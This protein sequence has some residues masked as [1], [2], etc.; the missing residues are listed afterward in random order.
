MV[1]ISGDFRGVVSEGYEELD[2]FWG[3]VLGCG[4]LEGGIGFVG[5]VGVEEEVR[6]GTEDSGYEGCVGEV[7]CAAETGGEVDHWMID[8]FVGLH[9]QQCREV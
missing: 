4:E 2:D 9:A 1:C 3:G 5:E 7:D 8:C 6:V